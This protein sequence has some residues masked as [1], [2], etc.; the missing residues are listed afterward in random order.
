MGE[1]RYVSL[2]SST[3]MNLFAV[4][5]TGLET[6]SDLY[7][8]G[9]TISLLS[10]SRTSLTTSGDV[11]INA[12]DT[13]SLFGPNSITFATTGTATTSGA[14]IA[15]SASTALSLSA[16]MISAAANSFFS[17]TEITS[18]YANGGVSIVSGLDLFAAATNSLSLTSGN[19]MALAAQ[20][21]L[22][23]DSSIITSLHA[24]QSL[25]ATTPGV[26][27]ASAEALRL[28]GDSLSAF[29]LNSAMLASDSMGSQAKC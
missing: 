18:M 11:V 16:P 27:S 19:G 26:L 4:G 25:F 21:N 15:A 2:G 17:S 9:D 10:N 8:T 7:V 23:L 1:A 13:A 24:S 12:G 22:L 28:Y 5:P 3:R 14:L 6:T 29:G 20:T